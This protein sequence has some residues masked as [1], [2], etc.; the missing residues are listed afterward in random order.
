MTTVVFDDWGLIGLSG[1]GG[2]ATDK[3]REA[4]VGVPA[5][6]SSL[7]FSRDK[8]ETTA[9]YSILYM[10]T[11]PGMV[12][13]PRRE[14]GQGAAGSLV[15]LLRVDQ[16]DHITLGESPKLLRNCLGGVSSYAV[17]CESRS[18]MGRADS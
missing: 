14:K 17:A 6:G 15:A 11:L 3:E 1:E 4:L 16:S 8:L 9:R 5:N 18:P 2:T 7:C 10:S 13:N 12:P